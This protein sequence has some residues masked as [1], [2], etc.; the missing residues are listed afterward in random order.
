MEAGTE[1]ASDA[2]TGHMRLRDARQGL[3]SHAVENPPRGSG[4]SLEH[5]SPCSEGLSYFLVD[6]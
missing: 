3:C 4:F 1:H 5:V 6:L 2:E